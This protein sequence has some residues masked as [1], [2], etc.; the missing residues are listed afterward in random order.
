MTMLITAANLQ[1]RPT[2]KLT[3]QWYAAVRAGQGKRK[4]S[5]HLIPMLTPQQAEDYRILM[6]AGRSVA[7]AL[8]IIKRHDLLDEIAA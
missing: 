2:R 8:C 5:R 7:D 6:R 4:T 3:A 1:D